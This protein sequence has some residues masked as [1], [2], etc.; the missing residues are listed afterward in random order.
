MIQLQRLLDLMTLENKKLKYHINLTDQFVTI[1]LHNIMV[2][3]MSDTHL[4]QFS[5]ALL[6]NCSKVVKR[7]LLTG[8]VFWYLE[9]EMALLRLV[10]FIQLCLV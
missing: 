4:N 10:F 9:H 6:L 2:S 3:Q 7:G 5:T 1:G 8:K